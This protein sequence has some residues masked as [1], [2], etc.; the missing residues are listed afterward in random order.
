[1]QVIQVVWEH[2]GHGGLDAAQGTPS[3]LRLDS[4]PE[5]HTYRDDGC[6]VSPSCLRCPLPQCKHDAPGWYLR[7]RRAQRDRTIRRLR[8]G[9]GLSVTQ[10][11]R[12][13]G[14]SKRTVF[15]ALHRA[16]DGALAAVG[17][18]VR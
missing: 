5:H 16:R 1:M 14:V 8:S 7:E 9:Q 12:R 4:L 2:A 13:F 17:G 18:G 6:E 3:R 11:A 15:R 10:L